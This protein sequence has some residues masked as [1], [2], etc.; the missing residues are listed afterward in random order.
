MPPAARKPKILCL[1]PHYFGPA[2]FFGGSTDPQNLRRKAVVQRARKQ[3]QRIVRSV[4]VGGTL[5]YCGFKCRALVPVDLDLSDRINDPRALCYVLFD[6]ADSLLADHTHLLVVEDDIWVP[7][8]TIKNLLALEPL[9]PA[10]CLLLPNWIEWI[11]GVPVCVD[12]YVNPG[13]TGKYSQIKGKNFF[14]DKIGHS[15][16]LFMPVE[17]FRRAYRG[18]RFLD[19]QQ[20]FGDMMASAFAN[21]HF[22]F[23]LYRRRRFSWSSSV[24]HPDG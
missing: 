12:T 13:W 11:L 2:I 17:T 14:E 19:H 18:R 8:A 16:F 6:I 23:K 5:V 15:G 1:V 21:I 24:F 3:L 22:S 9:L 20:F 4:G 10:D 7:H